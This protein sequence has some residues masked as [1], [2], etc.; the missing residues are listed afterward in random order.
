MLKLLDCFVDFI[1]FDQPPPTLVMSR[2]RLHIQIRHSS[3]LLP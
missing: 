1:F 2:R 3:L